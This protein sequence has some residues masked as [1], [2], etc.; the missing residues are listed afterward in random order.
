MLIAE[1]LLGSN[2]TLYVDLSF[3]EAFLEV[4]L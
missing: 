2:M 4:Y 3:S 1:L